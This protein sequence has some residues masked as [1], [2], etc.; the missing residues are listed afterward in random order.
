[1]LIASG[2][3]G[4]EAPGL[5]QVDLLQSSRRNLMA[6]LVWTTDEEFIQ[7]SLNMA[8][9]WVAVDVLL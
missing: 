3:A 5:Q 7:D 4:L 9:I 1:M 2:F 8:V 6:N